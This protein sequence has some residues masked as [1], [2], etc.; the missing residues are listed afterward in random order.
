MK[1][2]SAYTRSD[3]NNQMVGH[4]C[5]EG[6]CGHCKAGVPFANPPIEFLGQLSDGALSALR[7]RNEMMLLPLQAAVRA[8]VAEQGARR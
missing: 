5:V 4:F 2:Y 6:N 7:E 1:Q 3:A 8:I